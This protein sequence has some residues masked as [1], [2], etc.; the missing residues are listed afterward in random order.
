MK[1]KS[2]SWCTGK[3]RAGGRIKKRAKPNPPKGPPKN[4]FGLQRCQGVIGRQGKLVD[5]IWGTKRH[6]GRRGACLGIPKE[7]KK[8]SAPLPRIQRRRFPTST[9]NVGPFGDGSSEGFGDVCAR[10]SEFSIHRPCWKRATEK[11]VGLT[12]NLLGEKPV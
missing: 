12:C 7:N 9:C 2:P 3:R 6:L 8:K 10:K 11:R 1:K 4:P 5:L